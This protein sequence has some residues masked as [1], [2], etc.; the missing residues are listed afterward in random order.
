MPRRIKAIRGFAA[1]DP[2]KRR[3]LASRGG[4]ASSSRPFK[5]AQIAARAGAKG[6]AKTVVQYRRPR[7][8]ESE[9]E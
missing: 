9:G 6:G 8:V 5:D 1:M 4:S 7:N 3:E 2:E